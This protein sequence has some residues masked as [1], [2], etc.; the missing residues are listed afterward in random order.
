MLFVARSY[1]A[2]PAASG[3][4][5][6]SC[7][8]LCLR[9]GTGSTVLGK[10]WWCTVSAPVRANWNSLFRCAVRLHYCGCLLIR[11]S[12]QCIPEYAILNARYCVMNRNTMSLIPKMQQTVHAQVILSNC[13]K[14]CALGNIYQKDPWKHYH[15]LPTSSTFSFAPFWVNTIRVMVVMWPGLFKVRRWP[16]GTPNS[17][18][19]TKSKL[20]L[21]VPP[22]R[23][24]SQ[25]TIQLSGY[26]R[27]VT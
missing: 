20:A 15:R 27:A 2:S 18:Q 11:N 7:A 1:A 6:I 24:C 26:D 19:V 5:G 17:S 16:N 22:S 21:A 8:V 9:V 10:T 23:A 4:A 3:T 14:L 25:E 12:S 13:I